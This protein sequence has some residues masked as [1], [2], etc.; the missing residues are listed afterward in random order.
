MVIPQVRDVLS[1]HS[2]TVSH[3][4]SLTRGHTVGGAGERGPQEACRPTRTGR[5]IIKRSYAGE[6]KEALQSTRTHGLMVGVSDVWVEGFQSAEA[7]CVFVC[8]LCM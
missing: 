5:R 8:G 3:R 4:G 1:T 7:V 2:H 6:R